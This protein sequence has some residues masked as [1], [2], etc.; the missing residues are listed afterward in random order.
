MGQDELDLVF[1]ESKRNDLK[2]TDVLQNIGVVVGKVSTR[3]DLI[4]NPKWIS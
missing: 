4:I 3:D 1:E 2:L